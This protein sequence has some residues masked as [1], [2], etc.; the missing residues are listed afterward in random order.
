MTFI[1]KFTPPED[2]ENY[3]LNQVDKKYEWI[4]VHVDT[5]CSV[6]PETS[7]SKRISE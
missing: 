1:N 2:V 7:T 6:L 3:G 4:G 5:G